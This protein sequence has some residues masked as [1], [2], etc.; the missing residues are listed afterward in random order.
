MTNMKSIGTV[1][2]NSTT[3][4]PFREEAIDGRR[5]D[6]L[7]LRMETDI[8]LPVEGLGRLLSITE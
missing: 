2:A 6:A 1:K 4:A 7:R 5:M 8:T 3:W